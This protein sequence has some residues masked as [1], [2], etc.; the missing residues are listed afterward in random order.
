M[1]YKVLVRNHRPIR[2]TL[3]D[4]RVCRIVKSRVKRLM[5][6]R[7][8][9]PDRYLRGYTC[10]FIDRVLRQ[11]NHRAKYCSLG[12]DSILERWPKAWKNKLV[13][14]GLITEVK[15]AAHSPVVA[16]RKRRR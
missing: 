1:P 14:M 4:A 6:R 3:E 15:R 13:R 10:W 5:D 8:Q 2:E 16:A 9:D 12:M 7:V 11:P